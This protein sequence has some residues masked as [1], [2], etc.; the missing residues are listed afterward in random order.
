MFAA[1][2][3]DKNKLKGKNGT[4]YLRKDSRFFLSMSYSS[5]EFHPGEFLVP[6][7]ARSVF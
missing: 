4:K 7:R 6:E 5:A 2:S 1:A 3:S